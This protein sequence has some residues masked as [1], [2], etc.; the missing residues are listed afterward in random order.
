M[1]SNP[2]PLRRILFGTIL[3]VLFL[4]S[5]TVSNIITLGVKPF[6]PMSGSN[7]YRIILIDL[8]KISSKIS[9]S[10]IIVTT[11]NDSREIEL[12]FIPQ[13]KSIE[14]IK[15]LVDILYVNKSIYRS[16]DDYQNFLREALN[17][18]IDRKKLKPVLGETNFFIED[19]NSTKILVFLPIN[20]YPQTTGKHGWYEYALKSNLTYRAVFNYNGYPIYVYYG[21]NNGVIDREICFPQTLPNTEINVRVYDPKM[22]L[23]NKFTI[24]LNKDILKTNIQEAKLV[25]VE[26]TS[27]SSKVVTEIN[28]YDKLWYLRPWKSQYSGE[29]Q[30]GLGHLRNATLTGTYYYH[31]SD[32][33]TVMSNTTRYEVW[34]W[35]STD[36]AV[37]G[38]FFLGLNGDYNV[39]SLNMQPGILYGYSVIVHTVP[40]EPGYYLTPQD[41]KVDLDLYVDDRNAE[42]RVFAQAIAK[43]YIYRTFTAMDGVYWATA[44]LKGI[45][46]TQVS[47]DDQNPLDER[48]ELMYRGEATFSF[49]SPNAF[50]PLGDY[51]HLYLWV[52]SSPQQKYD[53]VIQVYLNGKLLG[54]KVAYRPGVPNGTEATRWAIF[55]IEGNSITEEMLSSMKIGVSPVLRVVVKGFQ[56]PDD[57]GMLRKKWFVKYGSL[58]YYTRASCIKPYQASDNRILYYEDPTEKYAA[59]E[60]M[61]TN[62]IPVKDYNGMQLGSVNTDIMEKYFRI[63]VEPP[64]EGTYQSFSVVVDLTSSSLWRGDESSEGIGFAEYAHIDLEVHSPIDIRVVAHNA[65]GPGGEELREILETIQWGLWALSMGLTTLSFVYGGYIIS[66]AG[67]LVT[68]LSYPGLYIHG[69]EISITHDPG[70]PSKTIRI[71]ATWDPGW[72][73]YYNAPI[74]A[75]IY[76]KPASNKFPSEGYLTL[77]YEYEA[78]LEFDDRIGASYYTRRGI[79]SDYGAISFP[80]VSP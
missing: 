55:A 48:Y 51:P 24:K 47:D 36:R 63:S 26:K 2:Q 73:A 52:I 23:L 13:P 8:G 10:N 42:I 37:T 12:P 18:R 64:I 15:Q 53:R 49:L 43:A 66:A 14:N 29:G 31:L 27:T 3:L 1:L 41:I 33:F 79:Y 65:Y 34:V 21:V 70:T 80:I 30:I 69:S 74:R 28:R 50:I 67:L 71:H 54:E 6:Y 25:R 20:I 22:S 59:S 57:Y 4:Q 46:E 17:N 56:G 39:W 9:T 72:A 44:R 5:I 38:L 61:Y 77:Y 75:V 40:E 7:N 76:M 58:T 32:R 45:G 16:Y 68:A 78:I 19:I 60:C 35:L 62:Y 11:F